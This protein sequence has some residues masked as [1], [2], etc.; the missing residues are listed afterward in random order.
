MIGEID[1]ARLRRTDRLGG[2]IHEYRLLHELGGWG[3]RH[4]QVPNQNFVDTGAGVAGQIMKQMLE[5]ALSE[6]A[7]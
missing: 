6:P 3:F 7:G 4:L 1:L 5:A 2:I